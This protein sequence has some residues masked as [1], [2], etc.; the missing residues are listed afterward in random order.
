MQTHN[1][2]P[3][4]SCHVTLINLRYTGYCVCYNRKFFRWGQVYNV[5]CINHK[6]C[7]ILCLDHGGVAASYYRTVSGGSGWLLTL[8]QFCRKGDRMSSR[9]I[10]L[11]AV[12]KNLHYFILS[13]LLLLTFAIIH[14]TASSLSLSLSLYLSMF[15]FHSV[16]L[17][18]LSLVL[19][20]FSF[21]AYLSL[22]L[23]VLICSLRLV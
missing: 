6:D 15:L 7:F 22:H 8:A 4:N 14:F 18:S 23:F 3:S 9:S 10:R 20:F 1:Y 21:L 16:F 11:W 19:S 17:F 5:M 12:Y 13:T 2:L